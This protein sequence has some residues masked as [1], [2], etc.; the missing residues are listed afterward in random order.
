MCVCV[1]SF[2]ILIVSRFSFAYPVSSVRF[3][4]AVFLRCVHSAL[5]SV[6]VLCASPVVL[7]CVD[8]SSSVFLLLPWVPHSFLLL[9]FLC[10]CLIW[11][12]MLRFRILA[13]KFPLL[14]YSF[15]SEPFSWVQLSLIWATELDLMIITFKWESVSRLKWPLSVFKGLLKDMSVWCDN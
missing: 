12:F 13:I 4:S 3:C 2:F 8:P 1:T 9:Q 6:Y 14:V 5:I 10:F 11:V 15:V 7:C